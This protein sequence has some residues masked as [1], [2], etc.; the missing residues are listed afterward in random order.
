MR[1][2]FAN[3]AQHADAFF[4]IRTISSEDH[5]QIAWGDTVKLLGEYIPDLPRVSAPLI[6]PKALDYKKF[7]YYLLQHCE[8]KVRDK[9]QHSSNKGDAGL[10]VKV[11]LDWTRSNAK[12]R[13]ATFASGCSCN[14]QRLPTFASGC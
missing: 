4:V 10:R 6:V 5:T 3:T 7:L 11:R 13:L 2:R 1:T 9:I 14:L 12:Q 8:T